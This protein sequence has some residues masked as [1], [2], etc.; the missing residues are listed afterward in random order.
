MASVAIGVARPNVAYHLEVA[1]VMAVYM[2][3]VAIGVACYIIGT[4]WSGTLAHRWLMMAYVGRKIV[5][6]TPN[7]VGMAISV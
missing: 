3:T 2:A 7:A 5:Y 1:F 6:M 4:H